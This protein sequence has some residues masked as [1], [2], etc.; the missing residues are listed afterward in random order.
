MREYDIS[1]TVAIVTGGSKG[2]GYAIVKE[3]ADGG[4]DVVV[5]SRNLNEAEAAADEV[6]RRGRTGLAIS[7]D[8]QK[9]GDCEMLVQKTV[10]SFSRLDILI[11]NA[12]T[13]IRKPLLEYKEADWDAILDTN[14][15]GLFFCSQFAA[16]E[17]IKQG[18]GRV[19]NIS[20]VGAQLAAPYLGPYCASKG[21]ITQLT[22]VC[23][24]EWA[25]YG[26]TVNAIG[27]YY[28]KTPLTEEWVSDPIRHEKILSRTAIKRLGEPEDVSSLLLMLVSDASSYITGQT[29][30][31]DG[32]A[33]AGWTD[34]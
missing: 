7:A 12:G 15:K 5:V 34:L 4:A 29:F 25:Q 27:P 19:V 32:G 17:M 9:P 21:G 11:N 2:I 28:I 30:Y 31:I 33:L 10:E 8:I 18:K 26:I 24:L 16:M 23:A 13:N 20:S 3:L 1:N 22:R 14:L 6:R